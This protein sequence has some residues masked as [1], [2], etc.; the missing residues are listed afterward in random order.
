MSSADD[1]A[2]RNRR[3]LRRYL[4]E[5]WD[6]GD[7]EVIDEIFGDIDGMRRKWGDDIEDRA[8]LK[9]YL[10]GLVDKY[11]NDDLTVRSL[12]ADEQE[13]MGFWEM[14]MQLV[15]DHL[16]IKPSGRAASRRGV[17]YGRVE[18]GRLARVI[19]ISDSR[20]LMPRVR[21][22]ARSELMTSMHEG[23]VIVDDENLVVDI[24]EVALSAFDWER[25]DALDRPV[26]EV[27]RTDVSIPDPGGKTDVRCVD[28]ARLFEM[29][30]SIVTDPKDERV[31]RALVLRE[32]TDR[33]RYE[34]QLQVLNRVLRHNLRNDLTVVGGH[35]EVA[36][37]QADDGVAS[38]LDEAAGKIEDLL[39]TAETA[40]RVQS[41][42]E[43]SE[44]VQQDLG[45]IVE[46]FRSRVH[47]EYPA[48]TLDVSTP[49]SLAVEATDAL[50]DALWE[51]VE[52]A[53][54][55]TGDS[56]HVEIAVGHQAGL[57]DV[58]IS[59]DGPG[60]PEHE[61][62]VLETAT[63]TDLEHGSGLG[64]WLAHWVLEDAG[65]DLTFA[66]DDGTTVRAT[67]PMASTD[68]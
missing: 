22:L 66:V 49:E 9:S 31:G 7:V 17:T 8:E 53:C 33:K 48:V 41:T 4:D 52:N 6:D 65:G 47:G 19:D 61:R 54:E 29:R 3:L 46:S 21:R 24:N 28:D 56:P 2:A 57:A 44:T 25:E 67:L 45:S 68:D 55:H 63:E 12:L 18:N 62:A 39:T 26:A 13:V 38:M 36:A 15:D 37:E 51:L 27:L 11:E 32:I 43:D 23:V 34:N 20:E 5:V 40:R 1:P 59:D 42:L 16:G 60:L 50:E 14:E 30:T 35:L 58:T 10:G 64:L